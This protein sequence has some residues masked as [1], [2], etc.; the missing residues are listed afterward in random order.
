MQRPVLFVYA[1]YRLSYQQ[2]S[3]E[4]H[5]GDHGPEEDQN[6]NRRSHD[7]VD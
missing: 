5:G 7:P 1:M 2:E 6:Q 3:T 4:C